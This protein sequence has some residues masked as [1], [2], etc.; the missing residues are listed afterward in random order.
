METEYSLPNVDSKTILMKYHKEIVDKS[1][2]L[3]NLYYSEESGV[4]LMQYYMNPTEWNADRYLMSICARYA[5]QEFKHIPICDCGE[6]MKTRN[7]KSHYCDCGAHDVF[8]IDNNLTSTVSSS[9]QPYSSLNN[10][11]ITL[12]KICG[13]DS[14]KIP[15]EVYEKIHEVRKK[16]RSE[17]KSLNIAYLRMIMKEAKL[18]KYYSNIYRIHDKICGK[19]VLNL[20]RC[21]IDAIYEI[22]REFESIY[23]ETYYGSMISYNYLIYKICEMIDPVEYKEIMKRCDRKINNETLARYREVWKGFC[24][25]MGYKCV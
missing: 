5:G 24:D 2:E 7:G 4:K 14:V 17:N 9:K 6:K 23:R 21:K 19:S 12:E 10:L 3:T 1:D 15:D 13:M 11:I 18:T 16:H 20:D 22:Y 8:Y 25:R